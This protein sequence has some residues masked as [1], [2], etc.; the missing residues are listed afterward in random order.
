M[1][2]M[3]DPEGSRERL[4][5]WQG[6]IDRLAED[7]KL[8]SDRLEALRVTVADS[9]GLVTVTVDSTGNLV[10]MVFSE[11]IKR[12]SPEVVS[13]TAMET[14]REAKQQVAERSSAII[15]ATLGSDS[16]A[17][18]AIAERV[19]GRLEPGDGATGRS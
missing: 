2:R 14:I 3:L 5:A 11:R 9:N 7:T 16:L 18:R 1:D 15:E 19:R 6:R 10:D 13:R 8:M 17:G 12:Q 4:A